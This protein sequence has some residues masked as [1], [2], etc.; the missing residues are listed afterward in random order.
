MR[1]IHYWH[2]KA[3]LDAARFA[4]AVAD[5]HPLIASPT[6]RHNSIQCVAL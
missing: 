6:E 4:L 3:H 5:I 2:R 1:Y